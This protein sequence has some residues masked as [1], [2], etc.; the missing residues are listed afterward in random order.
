M[1]KLDQNQFSMKI[2]EELP[3][4]KGKR[5]KAIFECNGCKKHITAFVHNM[6]KKN[7]VNSGLCKSCATIYFHTTHNYSKSQLYQSWRSMKR[8]CLSKTSKDYKN[9]SGRGICFPLE[10]NDFNVFKDWA[11]AAGYKYGFTIERVKVNENYSKENC[12]WI[13]RIK[14]SENKRTIQVNNK[15]GMRGVTLP[16]KYKKFLIK[17]QINGQKINLGKNENLKIAGRIYDIYGVV[18]N[19]TYPTNFKKSMCYSVKCIHRYGCIYN[20]CNDFNQV[21][22]SNF[23][24]IDDKSCMENLFD[25]LDRFRLSSGEDRAK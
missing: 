1:N 4:E 2:I 20:Y 5:N 17:K 9:Y 19:I 18:N 16:H 13:P 22:T 7:R 15:T 24:T 6:N 10:W 11:L 14:Q 3:H 8:R 21:D 25:L 23:N 12:I